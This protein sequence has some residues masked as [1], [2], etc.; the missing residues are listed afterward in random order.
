MKSRSR[1][2]LHIR[3]EITMQI[4]LLIVEDDPEITRVVRDMFLRES[5]EVTWATTGLEGWEG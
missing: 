1:D 3:E 2:T 4:R 5:Y